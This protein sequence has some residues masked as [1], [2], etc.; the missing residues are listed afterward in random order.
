[1]KNAYNTAYE[2]RTELLKNGISCKFQVQPPQLMN[3]WKLQQV[4]GHFPVRGVI[5]GCINITNIPRIEKEGWYW[6]QN[7]CYMNDTRILG[8]QT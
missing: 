2:Q 5:L 7:I 3:D 6:S 8:F 1:L 4:D